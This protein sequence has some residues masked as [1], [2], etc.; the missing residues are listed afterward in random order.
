MEEK[1]ATQPAEN[2]EL[3]T[4]EAPRQAEEETKK[5]EEAASKPEKKAKKEKSEKADKIGR[6]EALEKE[7]DGVKIL[8][9]GELEKKLTVKANKFS[10]SAVE[11]IEKAGGKVEVI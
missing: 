8:G 6:A 2:E 5:A 7:L 1:K 4:K 10:K 9:V 3:E 11:A